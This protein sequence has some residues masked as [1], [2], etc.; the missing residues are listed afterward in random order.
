MKTYSKKNVS[1]CIGLTPRLVQF[2][3][4]EGLVTPEGERKSQGRGHKREYSKKNLFEF[5]L[6]K[7]FSEVGLTLNA[8]RSIF[9]FLRIPMPELSDLPNGKKKILS[10]LSFF[11]SW[12]SMPETGCLALYRKPNGDYWPHYYPDVSFIIEQAYLK[13]YKAVIVLNVG[14]LFSEVKGY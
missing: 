2:Y 10:M 11:D 4:E 7:L 8:M 9:A 12:E 3:T 13:I 1:E 6:I 5:A 14:V